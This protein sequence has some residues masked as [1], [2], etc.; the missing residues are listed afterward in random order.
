MQTFSVVPNFNE[1]ENFSSNGFLIFKS[2]AVH[3]F[4]FQGLQEALCHRI[5]PTVGL[6]THVLAD[7]NLAFLF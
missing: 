3:P 5:V 2:V 6:S 7:E 1:L 4:R